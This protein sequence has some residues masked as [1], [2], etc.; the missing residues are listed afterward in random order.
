MKT[1]RGIIS[2]LVGTMGLLAQ[3]SAPM[4]SGDALGCFNRLEGSPRVSYRVVDVD[5]PGFRQAARITTVTP[6]GDEWSL[7]LRCFSTRA[8]R[9]GD[10]GV[11][12]FWMRSTSERPGLTKFVVERGTTPYT[13]SLEHVAG[14]RREWRRVS[15]P[16]AIAE[17]YEANSYNFSFW[18]NFEQQEIEIGG[19]E[20][21]NY[22]QGVRISDLRIP[23]YP[24]EGAEPD[25]PWRAEARQRIERMR[26]GDIVVNTGAAGTPVRVRMKKHA[27]GWATATDAGIMTGSTPDSEKY[28]EA[29]R[30]DFNRAGTENDLKWPFWETWARATSERGL[31]WLMSNG[32][33]DTHAHVLVW[34]G[35]RNLPPDVV[36]LLEANPVDKERLRQRVYK[37]IDDIMNFTRGRVDEW[38]VLNEPFDNFDLQNTLGL[39]EM[40]EWF[41][42]ARAADP[43]VKLMINDYDI[44]EDG[45][46]N[47]QHQDFYFNSIKRIL[48]DGGPLD[49]IGLQSHFGS[50]LTPPDR[51]YQIMNRFAS[52][53]KYLQVT[54]FDVNIPDEAVQAQY[55]RD[56][57]TISFSHPAMNGFTLW[58]FWEGRHWLPAAAMYRRDWTTKPNHDAWRDLIYR[59]WWTNVDGQAGAD[60]VFRTRGFLGDYDV[61]AQINGA[62]RKVETVVK[63]GE[64]NYAPFVD[65]PAGAIAAGGVVNA[66]SFAGGA[67]AP[68][69]IVTIY[70]SGFGPAQLQTASYVDGFLPKTVGDTRVLFDGRPAPMVYAARGQVSVIVPYLVAS[71]TNVEVEYMG[72]KTPVLNVAVQSASP[73]VFACGGNAERAVAVNNSRGGEISCTAGA[74]GARS[75][76]VVTMFLNGVGTL[77]PEQLD[78]W[79]PT[80]PFPAPA[81]QMRIFMGNAEV[82][83][84]AA[85]FAGLVYAGVTQ[86]NFCVPP[87]AGNTVRVEVNGVAAKTL[88]LPIE[89]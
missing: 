66:A 37:H 9:R 75:G 89:Q 67:V 55:T 2:L 32:Y 39:G 38:D 42:R 44:T 65:T 84:C 6:G 24:Y 53:G 18:V 80:A 78:G 33:R 27:F 54:E 31:S 70:G 56:Y 79:L 81:G 58:G 46:Y 62:W 1:M 88:N 10:V 19:I 4:I 21:Q 77:R 11:V 25:A 28:R 52:F 86:V 43:T 64:P 74:R 20:L 57:M 41:K 35:K 40:A 15:A 82:M 22:G 23:G 61:E 63:G 26:K 60:G 36:A 47:V 8:A 69:Q 5:G 49:G 83:P 3:A 12:T 7:R 14:A 73:G 50:S 68:G 17:D 45:G 13:K 72:V 16:F 87:G 71:T 59:E 76:D 34:P 29:F 48:D 30:R 85:S 51:V